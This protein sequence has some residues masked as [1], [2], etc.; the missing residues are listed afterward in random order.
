[1][2]GVL[3]KHKSLFEK[4]VRN[5]A[6]EGNI[7]IT[8]AKLERFLSTTSAIELPAEERLRQL[9]ISLENEMF[10][11]GWA[12][13][14]NIYQ[15][16]SRLNPRNPWVYHSWGIAAITWFEDWRTPEMSER[17]EIASEAETSFR[18]A[19]E[20]APQ[21]GEIA[22]SLGLL[23]Y[24]HPAHESDRIHYLEKALTSF[25]QALGWNTDSVMAQLY[26]A[27]CSYDWARFLDA[28][29]WEIAIRAYERVD[30]E[31]LFLECPAWR[32]FKY[33]E[34]LAA[35]YAWNGQ[36]EQ[37]VHL[38]NQLLGEIEMLQ[39]DEFGQLEEVANLDEMVEVVTHKLTSPA[40]QERTLEQVKRLGL[41][42][43]YGE[44]LGQV[45]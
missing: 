37:A 29:A 23:Y 38:F 15:A 39:E 10:E 14:R 16:A 27:H 7:A 34:Q 28:E 13:L 22:Y 19:L 17:L 12:G 1:M 6:D 30:Q 26:V 11:T 32:T 44:L 18:K 25:R 36:E 5:L 41:E 3:P 42:S 45:C 21:R 2:S 9:A 40:L 33:W 31:K 8:Q 43:I 35:C 24:H 4:A 20:L